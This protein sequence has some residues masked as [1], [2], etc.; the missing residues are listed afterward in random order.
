MANDSM[1]DM[2][3]V[4]VYNFS[5]ISIK[6]SIAA[7]PYTSMMKDIMYFFNQNYQI[8]AASFVATPT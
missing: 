8:V 1:T 3:Y 2:H 6:C 4:W 5:C 7:T